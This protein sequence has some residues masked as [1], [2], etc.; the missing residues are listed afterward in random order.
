[1]NTRHSSRDLAIALGAVVIAIAC[2]AALSVGLMMRHSRI[3]ANAGYPT[4]QGMMGW[5]QWGPGMMGPGRSPAAPSCAAPALPGTVVD[6]TLID[7]HAMI[8]PGWNG[9]YGPAQN[10]YRGPGTGMGMG[11]AG[12][13]RILINPATV[14]P[15]Q[16]SFRVTNAGALNHE[17]VVMPLAE[18]QY[19]G[20]RAIGPDGEVD[21]AGNLGEASRTCGADRGDGNPNGDGIAPG[22]SGWTTVTL[23]PGRYELIC[24]ITGHY[25]AGMYTELDVSPK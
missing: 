1:M 19:V 7:M 5:S 20:Q 16:V 4:G 6:V 13:M 18:G 14:P 10:G 23:T 15:G 9:Q 11:M 8:G 2:A 3:A 17:L 12:M 24:N 21:E 25:W 22:A